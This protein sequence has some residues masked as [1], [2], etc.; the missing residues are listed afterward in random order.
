MRGLLHLVQRRGDWTEQ[1]HAQ[2]PPKCNS[3]PINGQCRPTNHRIAVYNGPSL[4]GFNVPI[5]GLRSRLEAPPGVETR[6]RS[7]C[8]NNLV[9]LTAP[10][11]I[12]EMCDWYVYKKYR[13]I[14]INIRHNIPYIYC[15]TLP[16]SSLANR[17]TPYSAKAEL[18]DWCCFS[19]CLSVCLSFC[20]QDYSTNTF[21]NVDQTW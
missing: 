16:S 21:T 3:P 10:F 4:C 2:A 19:V 7:R 14:V 11:S 15:T 20:E 1:L 13:D 5:K 8:N 12:L 18:C 17:Y 6:K 9:L